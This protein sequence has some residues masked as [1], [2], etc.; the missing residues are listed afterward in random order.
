MRIVLAVLTAALLV[1]AASAQTFNVFHSFSFT[2]GSQ[3]NGDLL[4]DA[5]G[6]FYG[7]TVLGGSSNR[8]VVFKR[9]E[10][11]FA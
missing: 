2:D 6:N 3:P 1:T 5:A 9:N 10:L 11:Y 7:T 4:R 8:G